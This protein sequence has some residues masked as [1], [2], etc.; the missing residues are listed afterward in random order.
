MMNDTKS[1]DQRQL[2]LEGE[3]TVNQAAILRRKLLDALAEGDW[4]EIDLDQVT[5]VD[6]AGLQLLCSAHRTAAAEG[7]RLTIKNT[8]VPALQE[9]RTVSGFIMQQGCRFNSGTDCFWVGGMEQ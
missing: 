9:A 7:K 2:L 8:M 6:L 5:A 3:L 1:N 4:L